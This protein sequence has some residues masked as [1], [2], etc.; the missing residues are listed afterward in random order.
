MIACGSEPGGGTENSVIM[1]P[2][3]T[4][5]ILFPSYSLNQR[6]P[7]GPDVI[8]MGSELV[9]GS[10]NSVIMPVAV[11][12]PPSVAHGTVE[13]TSDHCTAIHAGKVAHPT[14][15]VTGLGLE[16]SSSYEMTA[17]LAKGPS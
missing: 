13:I 17:K 10:G 6:L 16:A 3:V 4:L 8:P 5:P 2:V 1:P 11:S 15:S 7:S 9:V 12:P 14:E